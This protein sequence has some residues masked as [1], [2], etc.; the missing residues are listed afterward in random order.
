[1]KNYIVGLTGGI[2]SGKSTIANLFAT[3]GIDY[4]DVDNVS[5]EI[6]LPGSG[7]LNM[8]ANRYGETILNDDFSLNR[9]Q[10]RQIIFNNLKEKQWLES[11]THPLIKKLT[12]EKISQSTSEYCLLVHPLLFET[13]QD[14]VCQ[15]VIAISVPHSIQVARVCSRDKSSPEDALKIINTQISNQERTS[16]AKYVIENTGNLDELGDKV[17]LLHQKIFND[18]NE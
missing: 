9:A 15:A 5:R 17:C 10:L 16:K 13:G 8:I 11:V 7:L 6:V 18:I 2:G 1:M 14:K 4:V 12:M 3:H